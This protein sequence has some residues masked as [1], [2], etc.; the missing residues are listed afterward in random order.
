VSGGCTALVILFS[1][2]LNRQGVGPLAQFGLRFVLYT[3]LALAAFLSGLDDKGFP[4]VFEELAL[5]V[6]IGLVVIAFPLYLVQKAIPLLPATTIAAVTALGPAV[7]FLMQL[8]EGRVDYSNAT[9]LG[10]M[11]YLI[12]AF[13][14]VLGAT[15]G[16]I[17]LGKS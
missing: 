4:M 6:L 1:V 8:F 11:L 17:S 15:R 10:L 9:L 7:V 13:L 16:G 12:G 3:L 2:R 5:I 14:T